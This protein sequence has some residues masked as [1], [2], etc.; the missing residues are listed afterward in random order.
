MMKE[1][2]NIINKSNGKTKNSLRSSLIIEE[3]K[4]LIPKEKANFINDYFI[5]I[6]QNHISPN[7]NMKIDSSHRSFFSFSNHF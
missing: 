1:S 3:G 2:W 6:N 4:N 5:K 7:Y